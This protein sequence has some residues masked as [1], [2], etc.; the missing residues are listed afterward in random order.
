M[1][2]L[3][4]STGRVAAQEPV[5]GRGASGRLVRACV[6]RRG[7][8][9]PLIALAL[10]LG[11]AV[12]WA[13]GCGAASSSTAS[14]T[15]VP[16]ADPAPRAGLDPV[17]ASSGDRGAQ[18]ATPATDAAAHAG[19]IPG[20]GTSPTPTTL[21]QV[22]PEHP[23]VVW[24]AG[25]S[26][27][28]ETGT[29]LARVAERLGV[30]RVTVRVRD[31]SG[32]CRPDFF[33]WPAL[34]KTDM[35]RFRPDAVVVLFGG[36]DGQDIRGG[37]LEIGAFTEAWRI[38]YARRVGEAMDILSRG[39]SRVFW[40]ASPIMQDA[41]LSRQAALMNAIY[42]READLRPSVVFVD[43]WTLFAGPSGDYAERLADSA[44]TLRLVRE[45][46]GVHLTALGGE[47]LAAEVLRLMR[48]VW[49][50]PLVSP[51]VSS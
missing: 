18:V 42:R 25:D 20:L 23:L 48:G 35:A 17:P 22:L 29:A 7:S 33:D 2:R 10:A 8:I 51:Q 40:L 41:E 45:P 39:G 6:R 11:L 32:L 3:P 15:T 21:R 44:G 47:R 26:L 24:V 28:A 13:A 12:S 34:M 37:G 14:E 19:S 16:T 49:A 36:N 50:L 9:L 27:V 30:M 38:E 43:S 46:D 1:S 4:A 31:C 5:A